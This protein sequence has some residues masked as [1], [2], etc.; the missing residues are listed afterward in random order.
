[1]DRQLPTLEQFAVGGVDSVRGYQE[2]Q[3]VRDQGLTASLEL[4]VP[5][6]RKQERDVLEAVPFFDVGYAINHGDAPRL[7]TS[8]IASESLPL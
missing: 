1:M 8:S 5:V 6:L 3:L 4:R 2:N 7:P